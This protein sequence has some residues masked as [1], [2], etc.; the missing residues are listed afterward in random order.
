MELKKTGISGFDEF[1]RGGL[2]PIVVL[3][4]GTADKSIETFA[5][6]VALY[7]SVKS[8]V[9]YFTVSRTSETIKNEMSAYNLDVS[10]QEETGRWKFVNLDADSYTLKKRIINEMKDKRSIVLD[11]I[12]ELLLYKDEKEIFEIVN[13]MNKQNNETKDLHFVLLTKG[14]QDQKIEVSL[15]HFTYG[16]IDFETVWEAEGV[17]RNLMI[18]NM[19]GSVIPT[20]KLPYTIGARGFTIDTATRIT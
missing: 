5:R 20:H 6:Q 15:Q 18:Q 19:L 17:S 2:P 4:R 9:T 12:S 1:L 3:L 14:M 13:E 7:R 8:K 16:T 10:F 11:S